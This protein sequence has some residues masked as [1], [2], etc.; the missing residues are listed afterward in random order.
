M[1]TAKGIV[2]SQW[3]IFLGVFN[4]TA[5]KVTHLYFFPWLWPQAAI[6]PPVRQTSLLLTAS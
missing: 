3:G 6:K 2:L 4:I 1:H 5:D